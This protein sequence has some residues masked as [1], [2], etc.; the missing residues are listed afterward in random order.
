MMCWSVS[1]RRRAANRFSGRGEL[2][3][4]ALDN[5][6][7]GRGAAAGCDDRRPGT[8]TEG[9]DAA[10]SQAAAVHAEQG[11]IRVDRARQAR[12]DRA[13]RGREE[14]AARIGRSNGI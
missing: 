5:P 3:R 11:A 6:V 8:G 7:G 4:F 14:R 10:R 1:E 12:R 13:G 9:R 2:T